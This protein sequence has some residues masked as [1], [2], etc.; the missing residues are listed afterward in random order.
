LRR[1]LGLF[2][3]QLDELGFSVGHE[4]SA[5]FLAVAS[6]VNI[7]RPFARVGNLQVILAKYSL[8]AEHKKCH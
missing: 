5:K 3:L 8:L 4:S 6:D 1:W 2:F 7:Y